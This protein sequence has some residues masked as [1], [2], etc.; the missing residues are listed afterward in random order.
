MADTDRL[1]SA[2]A[3]FTASSSRHGCLTGASASSSS[4]TFAAVITVTGS[5][6][7]KLLSFAV[8]A[9]TDEVGILLDGTGKL[10]TH[11]AVEPHQA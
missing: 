3:A 2:A 5:Q 6:H 8:E 9:A 4:T 10:S 1:G 11:S 7:V